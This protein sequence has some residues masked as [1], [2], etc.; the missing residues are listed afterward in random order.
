MNTGRLRT[1]GRFFIS[2]LLLACLFP[3]GGC[4][5]GTVT[6][7]APPSLP[8]PSGTSPWLKT[9]LDGT[10]SGYEE[11]SSLRWSMTFSE[12]ARTFYFVD[13]AGTEW[14]RGTYTFD[15][16]KIPVEI[17][18]SVADC[19]NSWY[20]GKI[21]H[22]IY[23]IENNRLSL[24]FYNPGDASRPA[25]FAAFSVRELTQRLFLM[26]PY[27]SG[28]P[29]P[30]PV[31][32]PDP[33]VQIPT[34]ADFNALSANIVDGNLDIS[35]ASST[36]ATEAYLFLVYHSANPSEGGNPVTMNG[37]F[38]SEF[39]KAGKAGRPITA[40]RREKI[41]S[42]S[43]PAQDC[44]RKHLEIMRMGDQVMASLL[45][46]GIRPRPLTASELKARG[47]LDKKGRVKTNYV[48]QQKSFWIINYTGYALRFCT[49]QAMGEH[50]YVYVDNN[51]DQNYK[52]IKVFTQS[53][54]SYFDTTIYPAVHQRIGSEWNP[55]IDGDSRV[56]IV[57]SATFNNAYFTQV[58][59][60]PQSEIPEGMHSNEAEIV[61]IDPRLRLE[62]S[63][64]Y[65]DDRLEFLEAVCGHEFTHLVRFNTKYVESYG[66]IPIEREDFISRWDQEVSVNEGCAIFTE[67]VILG[68]GITNNYPG[69][70]IM[71]A[72]NLEIYLEIPDWCLL[73]S[74]TFNITYND[75]IGIYEMGFL[76]V[77]YLY[78][79]LGDDAVARL[80]QADGRT[81][82]A[83]L[84]AAAGGDQSFEYFFDEQALSLLLAGRTSDPLYNFSGVDLTGATDYGGIHLHPAWSALTNLGYY[85]QGID[86]G[87]LTNYPMPELDLMEWSPTFVRFFNLSGKGLNIHITG[88]VP[89]A[90]GGGSVKAYFFYR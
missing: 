72:Q 56:F 51:D 40:Y 64:Q 41:A 32:T 20:V 33:N 82:L 26:T 52:D 69:M 1:V 88:L 27:I 37:A 18:L 71:R 12:Q 36:A 54:A 9:T 78:E 60:V 23:K 43:D 80:N 5:V 11:N 90:S 62:Q 34:P 21:S 89:P 70:N 50:C 75:W 57:L 61:Y 77:Q 24:A 65:V 55:G 48:G 3:L 4:G 45:A 16:G 74:Y 22:G 39:R 28:T 81:G 49:C 46:K 19:S 84:R 13:V 85:S 7:S 86:V 67:N 35:L 73:T 25:S 2:V 47:A 63:V 8:T 10:W 30:A 44:L 87:Q 15:A 38:S 59:E 6:G 68:R 76:I 53:L 31:F 42:I 83:S 17:E 29:A 58:D 14:Y 79:K 66:G